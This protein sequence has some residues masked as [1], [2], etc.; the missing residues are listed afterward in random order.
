MKVNELSNYL[1]VLII[2]DSKVIFVKVLFS[3]F[4]S[5]SFLVKISNYYSQ[6]KNN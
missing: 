1:K 4:Y 2:K 6:K 5:Y 3:D